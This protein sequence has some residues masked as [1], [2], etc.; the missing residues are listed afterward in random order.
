LLALCLGINDDINQTNK[1]YDDYKAHR[2][3]AK[4]VS[5]FT[6]DYAHLNKNKGGVNNTT[7]VSN[8]TNLLDLNFGNGNNNT[9]TLNNQGT[10]QK[11]GDI[12]DFFDMFK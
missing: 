7:S 1:R 10:N 8:N 5:C 4:F 12:N 2:K 3:P 11:V 6:R 9:N